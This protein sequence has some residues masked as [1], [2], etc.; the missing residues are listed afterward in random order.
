MKK[1]KIVEILKNSLTEIGEISGKPYFFTSTGTLGTFE[2][3]TFMFYFKVE[4]D[5]FYNGKIT[6]EHNDIEETLYVTFNVIGDSNPNYDRYSATNLG[7][8]V[9]LRIMATVV[10]AIKEVT[11]KLFSEY[12]TKTVKSIAFQTSGSKSS[13]KEL[14]GLGKIQRNKLYDSYLRRNLEIED[15]HYYEPAELTIYR[16]KN[17]I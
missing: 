6:I 2:D 7:I 13:D 12:G 16:L 11:E 10:L 5:P 4:E 9:M 1:L 8:K 3:R 14:D 15:I 17:P